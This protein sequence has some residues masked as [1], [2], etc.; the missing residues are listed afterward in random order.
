MKI[1]AYIG[2]SERKNCFYSKEFEVVEELPEVIELNNILENKDL[3]HIYKNCCIDISEVYLDPEQPTNEV[4]NYDYYKL[5]YFDIENY[6]DD[7]E[8]NDEDGEE[9]LVIDYLEDKYVCIEI[10]FDEESEE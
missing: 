7:K 8:R 10:N 2:Y 5:Q 9:T 1:K 4:Y 6:L 3:Q